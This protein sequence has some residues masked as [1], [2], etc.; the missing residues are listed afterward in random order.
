MGG[1]YGG[2]DGLD[3]LDGYEELE[4]QGGAEGW[5]PIP[6]YAACPTGG[7]RVA[8]RRRQNKT[9]PPP[10]SSRTSIPVPAP[11]GISVLVLRALPVTSMSVS[12]P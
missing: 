9:N 10:A 12:S 5:L 6:P 4:G 8:F 7:L 1:V 2:M 11:M 3:G